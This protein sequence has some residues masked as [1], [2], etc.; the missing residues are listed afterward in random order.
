MNR[1]WGG[2]LQAMDEGIW[3]MER[4]LLKVGGNSD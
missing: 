3:E 4:F 1:V 2:N